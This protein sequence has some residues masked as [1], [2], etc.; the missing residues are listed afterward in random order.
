METLKKAIVPNVGIH[1]VYG[2]G[3]SQARI[4]KRFSKDD[5]FKL[6]L[7]TTWKMKGMGQLFYERVE[8][9]I[10]YRVHVFLSKEISCF[11]GCCGLRLFSI[12][13]YK[14]I[15]LLLSSTHA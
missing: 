10:K 8:L 11:L 2:F 14:L 15:C 7:L 4:I 3:K 1:C 9:K 12:Q 6:L 13:I 5:E